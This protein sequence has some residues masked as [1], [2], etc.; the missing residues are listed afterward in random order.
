M[1]FGAKVG[2]QTPALQLAPMI[3]V[4]FLLLVFFITAS[5]FGQLETELSITVPAAEASE[6]TIRSSGEIIINVGRDGSIVVNQRSL[7]LGEL[8]R[9]LSRIASLYPGQ[10]VILRADRKTYHEDVVDV[11]NACAEARIWNISFA[12]VKEEGPGRETGEGGG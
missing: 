8:Q 11:L 4:V 9:V 6:R 2:S 7:T 3:D 12:T 10:P 5:V 1:N